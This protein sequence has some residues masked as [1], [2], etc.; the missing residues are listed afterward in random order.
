MFLCCFTNPNEWPHTPFFLSSLPAGDHCFPSYSLI[1]LS[2]HPDWLC[3]FDSLLGKCPQTTQPWLPLR[4]VSPRRGGLVRAVTVTQSVIRDL[5]RHLVC[6]H[7]LI[8]SCTCLPVS[9][10]RLRTISSDSSAPVRHWASPVW[11]WVYAHTSVLW[12]NDAV[13]HRCI[14]TITVTGVIKCFRSQ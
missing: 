10:A 4:S 3:F 2:L 11:V 7:L 9:H 13:L 8:S 12:Q 1:S 14:F 6:A 5:S